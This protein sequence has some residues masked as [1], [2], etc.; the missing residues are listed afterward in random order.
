MSS[1]A[2]LPEC[3][4]L[5]RAHVAAALAEDLGDRGDLTARYFLPEGKSATARVVARVPGV[6]CGS[7]VAEEVCRQVDEALR[8]TAE[9]GEGEVF[10]A[11]APLARMVGPVRSLVTA[12]R[13]L[14]NYLQ[15][16][17]GIATLTRR[18][19]DAVAGTKAVILDTR[20]TT[21]GWRMLEK[22]AVRCGGGQ[23]HRMGL[24]DAA[25][26]KDNHLACG[27]T[28]TDLQQAILQLKRDFP[29]AWV[30]LEADTLEQVSG[31]LALEGV[32][33]ILLD[34]MPTERLVLA[35]AMAGGKVPL[36][37]SGG[38]TLDSLPAIAATGVDFISVGALT[39]SATALDIGLDFQVDP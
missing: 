36:E 15:R 29:D 35:V 31:F 21:P 11:G 24:Y 3:G 37:A 25:M 12:E 1:P 6:F 14:L 5:I 7:V 4:Q 23:N 2:P 17:C 19:V 34:N 22:Y 27:L 39:H 20:K 18:H 26:V 8:W 30:E 32:D 38:V 10:S 16:L 9:L 28:G 33:R 13:T